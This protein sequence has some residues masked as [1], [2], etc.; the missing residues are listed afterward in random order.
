MTESLCVPD[1]S[2][3]KECSDAQLIRNCVDHIHNASFWSEFVTRYEP[4]LAR[5]VAKAYRRFTQGVYAPNWRVCELVQEVYLRL[6]KNDCDLLRR[7]RGETESAAKS[8][9]S[10]VAAHTTGD[11]LRRELAQKRI[12]IPNSLDESHPREPSITLSFALPERLADRDLINLLAQHSA[13]QQVQRDA[14]IFLLH[15]RAGLTAEEIGRADFVRLQPASVMSILSRTRNRLKKA[16][17]KA[18]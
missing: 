3:P 9:L 16:L 2:N 4:V 7:L 13:G 12:C 15:V 11:I 8:Y 17:K 14:M 6:L 1:Q 18:A 5:S 10:Q